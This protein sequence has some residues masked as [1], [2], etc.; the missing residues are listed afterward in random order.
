MRFVLSSENF[1]GFGGTETYT[2]TV[3]QQLD[4]LG[5]DVAI[6][7]PNRG[8]IAEFARGEGV[9]VLGTDALPLD[10]DVLVFGDAAT[11][12]DLAS[13]YGDAVRLF[14]SHSCDHALQ[15]PPQ[16]AGFCDTV[17]VLNDRVRR[18]VEAR[19]WHAP[20][21]RLSQPIDTVRFRNVGPPPPQGMR[22]LVVSNVVAGP[23]VDLIKGA[24]SAA[25]IDVSWIGATTAA[26]ATPE[27][28]IAN[29]HL[30]IAV[31]R[32][33]L[34]GMA[35]GRAVYVYGV[36][37]GDGWVTQGCYPRME[38]DGF[39]GLSDTELTIDAARL[40]SDLA[41]WDQ[42]MGELNRDLVF[43][44]HDA[45]EHAI[46]LVSIARGLS[47]QRLSQTTVADEL[48]HL[49]RREWRA[50]GRGAGALAEAGRLRAQVAGAHAELGD[51]RAQIGMLEE[52]LR[53]LRGTRRYRFAS[54]LARPL[55]RVR[56]RRDVERG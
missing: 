46:E 21:A 13:R 24:C 32:S 9:R 25:G 14:V 7:S 6:Y 28:A 38:A 23:R 18:A 43:S 30:V 53:E 40:T 45:R 12:H 16:L 42:T 47:S 5:H 50:Y 22:A 15:F 8:A 39:A 4:A 41:R 29:A 1:D 51:A 52:A 54:L 36:V 35:A 48:A 37:G 33:A 19:G 3:A 44:H 2:L 27:F 31:G 20:I 56:A 34:E 26:T 49:V 55:D 10:C 11:C 17:I